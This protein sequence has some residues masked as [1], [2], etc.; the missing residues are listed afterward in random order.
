MLRPRDK[1]KYLFQSII[2]ELWFHGLCMHEGVP[3]HAIKSFEN[4]GLQLH[5]VLTPVLDGAMGQLYASAVLPSW[6]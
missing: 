2:S 4:I 5:S 6:K 3:I 1:S